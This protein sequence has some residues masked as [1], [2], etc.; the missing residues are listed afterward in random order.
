MSIITNIVGWAVGKVPF[1]A[2]PW[3]KWVLYGLMASAL[4]GGGYH[5][6]SILDEAAQAKALK[7]QYDQ[8]QANIVTQHSAD[9]AQHDLDTAAL[10]TTALD[11][12]KIKSQ[13]ET[14]AES[15]RNKPLVNH[16]TEIIKDETGQHACPDTTRNDTYRLCVNAALTG[17][18]GAL[19][20]CEASGLPHPV[21]NQ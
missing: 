14:L 8:L 4:F 11:R 10:A 18:A 12:D 21:P 13:Y 7:T 3:I 9:I 2:S 15:V 16:S 6:K 20:T 5:T 19:A 17:D 1:L